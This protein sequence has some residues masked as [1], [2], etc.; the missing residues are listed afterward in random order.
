[1]KIRT[2]DTLVLARLLRGTWHWPGA[3]AEQRRMFWPLLPART[4]PHIGG[5]G[6]SVARITGRRRP[7][8]GTTMLRAVAR[9]GFTV[10]GDEFGMPLFMPAAVHRPISPLCSR[11]MEQLSSA[12]RAEV[13]NYRYHSGCPSRLRSQVFFILYG[14]VEAERVADRHRAYMVVLQRQISRLCTDLPG[15]FQRS[16][17]GAQDKFRALRHRK[18]FAEQA[19]KRFSYCNHS[20]SHCRCITTGYSAMCTKPD[21]AQQL[22][23][24]YMAKTCQSGLAP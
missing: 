20:A 1:M 24:M 2:T 6:R 18:S 15:T 12:A 10:G 14:T 11:Q 4:V 8:T 16:T 13:R 3:G 19:T 5:N 21:W 9:M 17:L 22:H 23:E 7:R